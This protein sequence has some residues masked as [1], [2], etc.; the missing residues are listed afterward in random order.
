MSDRAALREQL[1]RFH[2]AITG[3]APLDSVCDLVERDRDIDEIERLH[4]YEHAYTARIASVL[5]HDYP[6]L[7]HLVGEGELRG[8][9]ADYLRAHPPSNFSLREVGEH[10]A[11]W[12]ES[13]SLRVSAENRDRTSLLADLARLE[14]ARTEVFDGPDATALA[15]E[16]LAAHDPAEF[17]S[18]K[19]RLV[20]SSR[21]VT[22]ETN[23]DDVWDATENAPSDAQASDT[24]AHD[25]NTHTANAH[26]AN[27]HAS[28][29]DASSVQASDAD[30]SSVHASNAAPPASSSTT[31]SSAGHVGPRV[32][33]V[34]R[35]DL[36][37]L[38]R[39]LEHDEARIVPLM[40]AGTTFGAACEL[41]DEET[42][43]ERAIALLVRWLDAQILA[44]V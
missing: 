28:D 10:L 17:P 2:E 32:V 40:I 29:A 16:D 27:A 31:S 37:V 22:I 39:T 13:R 43:A 30:A 8:W 15:R 5:V 42:A 4:V 11:R 38:H 14:R 23:A 21:V 9:T 12:L 44:R 25:P 19:L 6:K 24:H 20:P 34:W 36:I 26:A 35:R 33:L 1:A 3:G 41:L 18:L 7:A